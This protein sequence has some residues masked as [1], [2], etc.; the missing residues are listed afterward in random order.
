MDPID[1]ARARV[2]HAAGLP[3]VLD[4]A[5][6]AFEDMLRAIEG[7]QDPARGAFAAFMMAGA[8]AA[9]ARDALAAAPSLPKVPLG[10]P[11]SATVRSSADIPVDDAAAALAGLSRLLAS[12]LTHAS[13][14]S[15]DSGDRLAC[16]Q[17]ARHAT[18]IATLLGEAPGP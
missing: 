1:T 12:R 8:A 15:A 3:A 2:E 10:G 14:R 9:R 4:A 7:Q 18:S 11:A 16:A 5:Y 6:E 17:A 13:D